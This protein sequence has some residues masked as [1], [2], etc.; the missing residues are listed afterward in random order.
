MKIGHDWKNIWGPRIEHSIQLACFNFV[1][2]LF[3]FWKSLGPQNF[4]N[5]NVTECNWWWKI[6]GKYVK[7]C[8]GHINWPSSSPP[9]MVIKGCCVVKG[10]CKLVVTIW[11]WFFFSSSLK[12]THVIPGWLSFFIKTPII[13]RT[14]LYK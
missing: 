9:W 8:V 2:F 4:H 6:I 3:W 10:K 11:L 13:F 12:G 14:M 5:C 7:P 1:I